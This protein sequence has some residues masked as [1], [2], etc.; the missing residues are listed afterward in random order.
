VANA[1]VRHGGESESRILGT[2]SKAVRVDS[3]GSARTSG[4]GV[5]A[6]NRSDVPVKRPA[7][8]PGSFM[9]DAGEQGG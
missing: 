5:A 4:N 3:Q 9:G 2:V 1:A 6:A 7:G 8:G